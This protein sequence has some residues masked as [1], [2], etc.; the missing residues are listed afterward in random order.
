MYSHIEF[1]IWL[2]VF[3][4]KQLQSPQWS[5]S[6]NLAGLPVWVV[7]SPL[8]WTEGVSYRYEP[9]IDTETCLL[10]FFS[11]RN[12]FLSYSRYSSNLLL[13]LT[14]SLCCNFDSMYFNRHYDFS[15]SRFSNPRTEERRN[16]LIHSCLANQILIFRIWNEEIRLKTWFLSW[17]C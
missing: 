8:K 14:L 13:L 10:D 9:Y 11:L 5:G 15:F 1:C 7:R 12:P 3:Y 4:F 17:I 6:A 2:R 16:Q